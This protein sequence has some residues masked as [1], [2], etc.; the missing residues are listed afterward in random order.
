MILQLSGSFDRSYPGCLHAID[1]ENKNRSPLDFKQLYQEIKN[2][3]FA[4]VYFFYGDEPYPIERLVRL[5]IETGIDDATRDFNCDILSAEEVDG[6]QIVDMAASFPM[7]AEKRF[8]FVKQIQKLT[9]SDKQKIQN[10]VENPSD[11]TV[12][13]LIANAVEIRQKFYK[14]LIQ[15]SRV[16]ES[17]PLYENQ[18]VQW[19]TKKFQDVKKPISPDGASYLVQRVGTSLWTLHHEIEKILISV[20]EVTSVSRDHV[21]AVAGVSRNYNTWELTD[22][23]GRKDFISA[24]RILNHLLETKQSPAGMLIDLTRRM[25]QLLQF[26]VRL[27]AG[28]TVDR[29]VRELKIRPFFGKLYGNQAQKFTIEELKSALRILMSADLA[30]KTGRLGAATC[31][32]LVLYD[33]IHGRKNQRYF[34]A[35]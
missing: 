11:S 7:M 20:P 6:N 23:V 14:Q 31:M 4:P 13:V 25:T 32:T 30:I 8:V 26:R 24:M 27:D 18:A 17:K 1:P 15:K 35:A 28:F 5:M 10:Y 29:I 33:L 34:Q 19:V 2:Q 12:L 3:N 16:L 9:P 21:S 22:A